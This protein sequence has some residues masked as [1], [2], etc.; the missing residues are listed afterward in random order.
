[1][2]S[3]SQKLEIYANDQVRTRVRQL[4]QPGTLKEV[5]GQEVNAILAEAINVQ[6]EAERNEV[7][8]RLPYQRQEGSPK[9]NGFKP[10][11]MPGFFGRL[12]LRKPVLRQGSFSSTLLTA[13]KTAGN[14]LAAFLAARFWLKGTA[15]RAV[16]REVNSALGTRISRSTVSTLTNALEP[17]VRE[18]EQRPV[19]ENIRYL[20]LD[21]TYLPLKRLG[22]TEKAALFV[23]LGLD[24][25]GKRHLLGFMLGEKE[26][27]DAWQAFLKDLIRRGLN[28]KALKL[29]LSDEHGAIEETVKNLLPTPHQL[30]LVHKIRNLK[31]RVHKA[32]WLAFYADFH[33]I[34]WADSREEALKALGRF[35]ERWQKP[36]P[37][38]SRIALDRFD[39]FTR[40]MAEPKHLWRT[41]RSTNPIER[42]IREIKRRTRPAGTMHSELE[43]MKIAW[44]VSTDQEQRWE[45]R[46]LW[47]KS[48]LQGGEN[49]RMAA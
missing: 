43:V 40:F 27:L 1:M 31:I 30:C 20:F 14:S 26:N 23:A 28:P 24:Q 49:S 34:Y 17:M 15:T 5:L 9:R 44:S 29:V 38:A 8:G 41:L 11:S 4:I 45:S 37:A 22:F 3:L 21:A 18:W 39:D 46:R 13:L 36:Y 2:K 7:L 42:F 25:D 33:A 32:H 48:N 10:V 12:T 19:P 6:L 47:R 16:A 35:Q